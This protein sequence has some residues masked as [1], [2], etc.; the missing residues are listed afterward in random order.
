MPE[1]NRHFF[2]RNAR[3]L[4]FT[5][6]SILVLTIY[7]QTLGFDFINLDDNLYIYR[8][9]TVLSGLNWD[10]VRWAFTAFHA[11]NWH[12]VTWLSHLAD[13]EL[14]GADPGGHH[15]TNIFFHLA[16]TLLAFFVFQKYTGAV[17]KS[18][19]VAALF[20]VHPLHVE[21]VAWVSERK[22]VLSAFFW[23][24][25]MLFYCKYA[26][27]RQI[28]K[29][30]PTT[31]STTFAENRPAF[32]YFLTL[33]FFAVGLMSKP[34]LV[35][36]PMVLLLLDFWSL[37]RLQTLRDLPRLFLEKIPFLALSAISSV[38][39]VIA[40]RR[41]G[42]FQSLEMLPLETRLINSA[43]SYVKYIVMMFYPA[44][45]S[46][47]YPYDR[48][49]AWWQIIGSLALLIGISIFCLRQI[50]RRKYFLFG[51]LWF[52]GT[53]VPVI[54]LV[55]VGAQP[56]ADRYTY[57]PYFGLFVML[58]WGL[59]EVFLHLRWSWSLIAA[60]VIASLLI[61][62]AIS[63]RQTA[64]WKNDEAL[65]RHSL[66]V[67]TNNFL[68]MQN[69]CHALMVQE[70]FD[71]AEALCRESIAAQPDY[72]ESHNTLGVILVRKNQ[73]EAG[74]ESFQKALVL[75][76]N[77][78][79]VYANLAVAFVLQ[80]NPDEAEINLQKAVELNAGNIPREWSK[81]YNNIALAY[82]KQKKIEEAKDQIETA[83]R[84]SPFE[85]DL[86]NTYGMIL[87]DQDK[88]DE[89]AVQ[90]EKAL[91]LNSDLQSARDNLN[92]LREEK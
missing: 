74:I 88:K 91:E 90:F 30:P 24:L 7:L 66:S 10:S 86:Y 46:V 23:L 20:A 4:I 82:L 62:S 92:K 40:Q 77:Y 56:L 25:T 13:V 65:Y 64:H 14:F 33:L 16:N 85:A 47:W 79:G 67:T 41:G 28:I 63:Y 83:I 58:V 37:E 15:A 55:Q 11:A 61:L 12:P 54:G 89:A 53:L 8:N 39:T 71:E 5:G 78:A 73:L 27:A 35:T 1:E 57:V 2:Q 81:I 31:N 18:A 29:N 52:L 22:D 49:F 68:I 43:V 36:L 44:N 80:N 50:K 17:W 48:N 3:Y 26:R 76:P 38:I 45:L 6:L 69:Y 60:F 87:L 21:S 34:M 72:A 42:A 59:A 19:I 70:R 32:Y 75:S 84:Q 51:W 9:P